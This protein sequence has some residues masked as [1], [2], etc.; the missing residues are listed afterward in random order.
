ML[1]TPA[2]RLWLNFEGE[3]GKQ[4]LPQERCGEDV[5]LAANRMPAYWERMLANADNDRSHSAEVQNSLAVASP[6]VMCWI[7]GEGFVDNKSLG[8]HCDKSHG[9]YAEYRKRLFWRAQKDG[10]KPLLPWVKRHI[11]Q[12]ATFHTTYSV[13]GS[14][15]LKWSQPEAMSI[16]QERAEV[17]CVVCARK[18]WLEKRLCVYLWKEAS[19]SKSLT[20]L[21]NVQSGSSKLLTFGADL[22]FGNR[23]IINNFLAPGAYS[24]LMPLIPKDHLYASSVIHPE[25]ENMWLRA[26]IQTYT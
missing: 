21:L 16:A 8:K 15:C 5:E 10:F 23:H 18:D 6:P 25:D 9:D 20:D 24:E 4:Y 22:C 13:P 11:L 14:F 19:D 26:K 1:L 2:F 3:R 12:A 7:C 17:A